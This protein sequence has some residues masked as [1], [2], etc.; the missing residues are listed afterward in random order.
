MPCMS[1][2]E[3]GKPTR[4]NVQTIHAQYMRNR[5]SRVRDINMLRCG[6]LRI[7]T[8]PYVRRNNERAGLLMF[9]DFL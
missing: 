2:C 9:T 5:Y 3:L 6:Y 1:E 4:Y 7:Q 8:C